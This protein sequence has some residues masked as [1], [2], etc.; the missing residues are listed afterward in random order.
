MRILYKG[1]VT[2][3]CFF[4][5]GTTSCFSQTEERSIE[6]M[7]LEE[8]LDTDIRI[9]S[10]SYTTV[11][12]SPGIVSLITREEILQSGARDITDVLRL[13]PG[14]QLGLDVQN[15]LGIGLR[16]NWVH[17]GKVLVQIDGNPI[18]DYLYGNPVIGN[19]IAVDNIER[20]EIIRG[21]GSVQYGGFA[22][23]GVINVITR[24]TKESAIVSAK[25]GIMSEGGF[26]RIASGNLN[27]NVLG[28]DLYLNGSARQGVQSDYTMMTNVFRDTALVSQLYSSKD[29]QKFSSY[30]LL[31]HAVHK[32]FSFGIMSEQF[33]IASPIDGTHMRTDFSTLNAHVDFSIKND[34]FTLTP[35]LIFQRQFPWE[36]TDEVARRNDSYFSHEVQRYTLS[37]PAIIPLAE[38]F[39]LSSGLDLWVDRGLTTSSDTVDWFDAERAPSREVDYRNIA[40]YAMGEWTTKYV[41]FTFGFRFEN[42]S[43]FGSAFVP[44]FA[45]TKLF[46]DFHLKALASRAFRAPTIMNITAATSTI[47]PEYTSSYEIEAG[48]RLTNAILCTVNGFIHSLDNPIVFRNTSIVGSYVNGDQSGTYGVEGEVRIKTE[49]LNGWINYSYYHPFQNKE[50]EYQPQF[51]PQSQFLA[52]PSHKIAFLLS[53]S[54][55][56]NL[57]VTP[58]FQFSSPYYGFAGIADNSLQNSLVKFP[59]F[60]L[61]TVALS[62]NAPVKD[63]AV[64]LSCHNITNEIVFFPQPYVSDANDLT[65]LVPAVPGPTREFVLRVTYSPNFQ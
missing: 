51:I 21:P 27:I 40:A 1:I 11:Q 35:K 28:F 18:N 65:Q 15:A 20:I 29:Q 64:S 50:V 14:F 31:M 24:T 53:Y 22:G 49:S 39:L 9:A 30:F 32:N 25:A 61:S 54:I 58:S 23:L 42:N 12:E 34:N 38:N 59:A 63:V 55:I 6:S 19:R 43:A 62:W 13:I 17:E 7:S 2:Y 47:N 8:L 48:Y 45:A 36:T 60:F 56:P 37:L 44:R 26:R 10:V 3:C 5:A 46:G 57:N 33:S 4:I 41:N 16:G 52:F